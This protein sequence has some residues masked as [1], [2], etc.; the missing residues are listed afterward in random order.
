MFKKNLFLLKKSPFILNSTNIL[1]SFCLYSRLLSFIF[2]SGKK[3]LW[4]A[5]LSTLLDLISLKL[6][7]SKSIIILKI[8]IRLF[9]RVES[10]KIKVR[11]RVTFIPFFI[12]I[13]RSIF[14]SLKWIFV[15][16]SKNKQKVSFTVKL[17]DEFI[18]IL[19]GKSCYSLSKLSE[20]NI[21]AFKNRSNS[22][23]RWG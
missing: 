4:N 10:K 7:Y 6:N 20:N 22:H 23:Y 14:L 2:K 21:S 18:E 3:L 11:K 9:T 17:F 15:G 8:F 12:K 13:S 5:K 16:A 19:L 1:N